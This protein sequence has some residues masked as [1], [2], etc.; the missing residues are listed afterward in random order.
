MTGDEPVPS[1]TTS[2]DKRSG[3]RFA[4]L[5]CVSIA[6]TVVLFIVGV[7]AGILVAAL[8]RALVSPDTFGSEP[9]PTG[10]VVLIWV[11]ALA[12]GTVAAAWAGRPVRRALARAAPNK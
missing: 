8:F 6:V 11:F 2:V 4:V 12:F 10:T 5:K 7:A 3:M 1:P 9:P